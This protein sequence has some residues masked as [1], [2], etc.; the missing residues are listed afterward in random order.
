MMR[1]TTAVVGIGETPFHKRGT[2]GEP[3]LKLALRAIVAAAEDAGIAPSEIDGFVSYGSERNDGQRMMSALG[4]E[5]LRFGALVWTHGG[6]IPGALGLAATAIVT[7][8]AEVVAVYRA[9]SESGGRRLRVDVAQDDTAAQ[10]L[11]NG[12]DGPAQMCALR[13]MRLIEAEGVP[14]RTLREMALVSYHH[15]KRNPRAIGRDA[16]LDE[17]IYDESRWISEPYRLFDCSR[18]SDAGVAVIMVSAERAKDL[19]QRPAYLLGAPMGAVKGWGVLEENHDP[20]WSA[21]FRGVAD[22]LWRETGYGPGDVDVAQIYENMTGM[23]VSALIE[24]RF[25]DPA[26]AGDFITFDNLT[27]PD[28]GL[29]INT[30]GGNL[31]EGFIHGMSLV[32]EAVR[33]I[34]GTSPNQV[35]GASLSLM[36]GGPGD[37]V[38][39]TAL[40]G[41]ASTV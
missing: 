36:T 41:D 6:G 24:H 38:V 35:P 9:M 40:L 7:G 13:T 5:E 37:P 23:G 20:Y 30:S 21:G 33:Q 11:V 28:G 17:R 22:R 8:Q 15:A 29:P 2:S 32:S 39:S 4:T 3:A 31:A 12:L 18:E 10:Q 19:R 16:A 26:T 14:A 27:A 34:R 1:G 25:C